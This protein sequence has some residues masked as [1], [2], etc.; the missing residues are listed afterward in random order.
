MSTTPSASSTAA[1]VRAAL[2]RLDMTQTELAAVTGRSQGYWS[3]RLSGRIALN[4]TD[5]ALI[6][7]LTGVS[8]ADLTR[9]A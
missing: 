7:R 6:S 2:A 3:K 8:I 4:V 9:A 1:E 5:L